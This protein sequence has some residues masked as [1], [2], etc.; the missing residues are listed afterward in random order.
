MIISW[1][2]RFHAV[3]KLCVNCCTIFLVACVAAKT[4]ELIEVM[5]ITQ[6]VESNF[7]E[8]PDAEYCPNFIM[9]KNDVRGYFLLAKPITTK[10]RHYLYSWTPCFVTVEIKKGDMESTWKIYAS[11]VAERLD[12]EGK[13]LGCKECAGP[14]F[15]F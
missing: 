13:V 10:E 14:F 5:S 2:N 12:E 9:T 7:K 6:G 1:S 11:S 4:G 3:T 15:N 8:H